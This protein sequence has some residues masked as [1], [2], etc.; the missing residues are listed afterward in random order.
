MPESGDLP[1]QDVHQRIVERVS[2]AIVSIDQEYRYTYLNKK[3]E[4]LLEK[5]AAELRGQ[6]IWEAFPKII[7][8]IAENKIRKSLTAEVQTSYERY[9]TKLD[10]W[11][12]VRI[13]PSDNGASLFFTDITDRKQREIE[14]TRYEQIVENLPVA[15][16]QN[17]LEADGEFIFVNS[18]MVEMFD[19]ESKAEAKNHSVQDLYADPTDREALLKEVR[20]SGLVQDKELKLE[21]V[22]GGTF[23]GSTTA[24]I[25]TIGNEK[26]LLGIIQDITERKQYQDALN[27]LLDATRQMVSATTVQE[28]AD[29]VTTTIRESIGFAMSGVHLYHETAGGLAPVSVS[30]KSK[31]VI[32]EPPVLDEGI[33]WQAY[34]TGEPQIYQN[35]QAAN[36]LYNGQTEIQSEIALPLGHQGVL[37]VSSA[38][39]DAFSDRDITLAKTLAT[40]ATAVFSRIQ[41]YEQLQQR[42]KTVEEQR[43]NLR[44]VNKIV[45]HDIRND[46]QLISAYAN[47]LE[48][49]LNEFEE[50]QKISKCVTNAIEVTET[51]REVTNIVLQARQ[52]DEYVNLNTILSQQI[53]NISDSYPRSKIETPN[54]IPNID[55]AGSDM[56][57]SV[58]RNLLSNAIQHNDK[59]VPEVTVSV[60]QTESGAIIEIADNGPGIPDR[61]KE[62]MFEEGNS[63]LNSDGTGLGLYLVKKIVGRNNGRVE[64]VDNEPEG[65]V[66]V[67]KLPKINSY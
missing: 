11:F 14:L 1:P 31:Q 35:L 26:Y 51:A 62:A 4:K 59:E 55:V 53:K 60:S 15:V 52:P 22:N 37:L 48:N 32:E 33:G 49:K 29:V 38:E 16:G 64:V 3:A 39:T 30:N 40:N 67:V 25:E 13:Y 61:H 66:F 17:E 34:K 44:I 24:S 65:S 47:R 7:D 57:E 63:G 56:L 27:A 58:F 28:V 41:T 43:D 6:T 20:D 50:P 18:G 21:T 5:S 46:L 2:D 42:E 54:E 9:N 19:A 12:E 23:W 45:R 8:T 10:R 36:E